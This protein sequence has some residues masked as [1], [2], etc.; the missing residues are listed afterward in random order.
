MYKRAWA[1]YNQFH[2][3]CIS[4]STLPVMPLSIAQISSFIAFMHI[5]GYAPST[6]VTYISALGYFH[7]LSNVIDPTKNFVVQKLLAGSFKNSPSVDSRLPIT[8]IV[9]Y[10]LIEDIQHYVPVKYNRLLLSA[11]FTVAFF[12]LLRIGELTISIHGDII[13]HLKDLKVKN[14]HFELHLTRYK[15]SKNKGPISIPLV[16]QNN[17]ILCPVRNLH[18]YLN[19]RG[20]APGPLFCYSTGKHIPRSFFVK[21]LNL[22]IRFIGLQ[23]NLYKSHSFRIGGASYLAEQGYSDSQIREMGRWDSD[24]FKKYI[25][26]LWLK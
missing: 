25:R 5:L 12:A 17:P 19:I 4:S 9:L 15:H 13:L 21:Y 1:V 8:L 6:R 16:R 20:F 2:S 24:S 14:D 26:N 23:T 18:A 3:N 7:K 10:R 22:G 11:M